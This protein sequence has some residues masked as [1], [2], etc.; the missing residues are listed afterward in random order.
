MMRL[1]DILKSVIARSGGDPCRLQFADYGDCRLLSYDPFG[2]IPLEDEWLLKSIT[3]EEAIFVLNRF[4]DGDTDC[5]YD[6]L[7]QFS[8][9]LVEKGALIKTRLQC[10]YQDKDWSSYSAPQLTLSGLVHLPDAAMRIQELLNVVPED[11]RDGLFL[12]CW[13]LNDK[14]VTKQVL[15]KFEEW[16]ADPDWSG[17]ATG[18]AVW[19]RRF[20]GKFVSQVRSGVVV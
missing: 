7:C 20:V 16:V 12:A 3:D 8:R 1:N 10:F 11:C 15:K 2:E 4:L 17:A 9:L 6:M 13:H 5:A 19:R 18:E 14:E